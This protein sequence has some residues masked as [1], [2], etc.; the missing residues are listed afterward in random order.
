M[1]VVKRECTINFLLITR[2]PHHHQEIIIPFIFRTQNPIK[3]IP[4]SKLSTSFVGRYKNISL[5]SL[6]LEKRMRI[7]FCYSFV[8]ILVCVYVCETK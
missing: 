8:C 3:I 6:A 5:N 1:D 2:Q 7:F 4:K